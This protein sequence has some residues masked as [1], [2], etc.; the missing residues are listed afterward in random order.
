MNEN[1]ERIPQI[2]VHLKMPDRASNW[3]L[4]KKLYG[5]KCLK[6]CREALKNSNRKM[7]PRIPSE[8]V[9]ESLRPKHCKYFKKS[10]FGECSI[11]KPSYSNYLIF[12]ELVH[13]LNPEIELPDTVSQYVRQRICEH[14]KGR[15][16]HDCEDNVCKNCSFTNYFVND[17]SVSKIKADKVGATVTFSSEFGLEFLMQSIVS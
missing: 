4:F 3:F 16:R 14:K 10:S 11:C 8:T 5:E 6:V 12:A 1:G 17:P 13:E 9:L 15:G 2:L 7:R